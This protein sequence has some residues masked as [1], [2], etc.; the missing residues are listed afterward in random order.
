MEKL[1]DVL[2]QEFFSEHF[3]SRSSDFLD[4]TVVKTFRDSP[5]VGN[6]KNVHVWWLLSNGYAV[7]WNENA[8]IGWSFPIKKIKNNT[9][10]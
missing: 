4:I 1:R 3:D 5:W 6:H 2:P 8:N 9:N 10:F 7:G